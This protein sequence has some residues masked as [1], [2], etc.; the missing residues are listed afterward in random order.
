MATNCVAFIT[1]VVLCIIMNDGRHTYYWIDRDGNVNSVKSNNN[2]GANRWWRPD[3]FASA[4]KVWRQGPKG[5]VQLI[6]S[7]WYGPDR[8]LGWN[9]LGYITNIPEA[10]AEFSWVVLSA[11]PVNIRI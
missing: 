9:Y 7:P 8:E 3:V 11:V 1:A 6:K 10:M 5:G 4:K 2:Y